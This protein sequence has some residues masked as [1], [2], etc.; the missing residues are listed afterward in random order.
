MNSEMSYPMLFMVLTVTALISAWFAVLGARRSAALETSYWIAFSAT[1]LSYIL[2]IILGLLAYLSGIAVQLG[3]AG[4]I[5]LAPVVLLIV[6][7]LCHGFLMRYPRGEGAV[8]ISMG[9]R[10]AIYQLG[11]TAIA[12]MLLVAGLYF[13]PGF[14]GS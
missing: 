12:G 13:L 9:V 6:T 5:V 7:A 1:M 4:L 2:T 14:L 3:S 10:I 11:L 8:G